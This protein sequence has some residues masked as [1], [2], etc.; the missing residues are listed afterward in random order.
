MRQGYLD[1]ETLNINLAQIA[2]GWSQEPWKPQQF[3]ANSPHQIIPH[4]ASSCL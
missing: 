2:E 1:N 3:F 4:S